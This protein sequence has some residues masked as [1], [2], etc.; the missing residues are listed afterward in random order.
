MFNAHFAL[1]ANIVICS[2]GR[3]SLAIIPGAYP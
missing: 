3:T 2:Y 1:T